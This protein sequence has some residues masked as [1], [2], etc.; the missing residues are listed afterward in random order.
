[1]VKCGR[2]KR[3]GSKDPCGR[4]AGWGTPHPGYGACK[5][6]G[7]NTPSGI[8]HAAGLAAKDFARGMLGAE[9]DGE[10]GEVMFEAVRLARG[11]T[12]YYRLQVAGLEEPSQ[13]LVEGLER[14]I[15]RQGRMAKM[16]LDAGIDERRMRRLEAE[17]D[18]IITAAERAIAAVGL[19]AAQRTVFARAF[20]RELAGLEGDVVEGQAHDL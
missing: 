3:Q 5:L 12:M 4:G 11:A 20:G 7:G 10:P 16:A 6:H 15:E 9:L 8:K 2:P 14:A 19:D 1:M 18:L 13:A 17:A